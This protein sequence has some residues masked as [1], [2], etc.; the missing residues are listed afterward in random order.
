MLLYNLDRDHVNGSRGT[1][2]AFKP[3]RSVFGELKDKAATLAK[4]KLDLQRKVSSLESQT[5]NKNNYDELC[6]ARRELASASRELAGVK[7][8]IAAIHD[9]QGFELPSSFGKGPS[10]EEKCSFCGH[11]VN[12]CGCS[13]GQSS[14]STSPRKRPRTDPTDEDFLEFGSDDKDKCAR[15]ILHAFPV[16]RFEDGSQGAILPEAFTTILRGVG[17]AK[18]LQVPLALAWAISIH[19]SQGMS[20]DKLEVN[21]ADAFADGQA[22]VALSRARSKAGLSILGFAESCVKVSSL[23]LAFDTNHRIS[24]ETWS[25]VRALI[26]IR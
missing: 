7:R 20:I 21:L 9:V 12:E 3:W 24:V 25:E 18:R 2:V 11:C 10:A 19:K 6:M 13:R 15:R 17:M 23:A 1:I 16:V 4:Q 8:R 14:Q 5:G 26:S 22:Y